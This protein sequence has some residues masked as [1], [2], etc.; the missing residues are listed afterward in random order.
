M[1]FSIGIIGL[2]N[3][4]KSTLFKALTKQPVNI[5]NYPFCTID[6]NIGIVTVPDKRLKD[7][8]KVIKPEKTTPT[9]IEFVDIAGLVKN[10]HQGEGLGNQFLAH[11]Y[12]VDM[13]L[14]IT[15]CFK[16]EK[17]THMEKD[18]DPKRDFEIITNELRLKDEKLAEKPLLNICNIQT[19]GINKE[20]NKCDLKIDIKLELET[21]ELSKEEQKELELPPSKLNQLIKTCYQILDLITFYTITGGQETR[22][23]TLKK[24]SFAPQAGKAVHSDFKEKFIRAE[25]IN[26]EKLIKAGNWQKAREKGILQT[27]GKEYIVQDGDVIE[28]KI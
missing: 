4:G 24:N 14:L 10:A 16:D 5:S 8:S 28:F 6:P 12:A 20:F 21:S 22:A 9:V 18:I 25:V 13:V 23:W 26:W 27:Q 11:I 19:E 1:S 15:R 3:V 2:P 7:I 17:I